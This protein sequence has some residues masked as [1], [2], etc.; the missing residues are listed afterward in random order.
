MSSGGVEYRQVNANVSLIFK[1]WTVQTEKTPC[2]CIVFKTKQKPV[3]K[4]LFLLLLARGCAGGALPAN[5]LNGSIAVLGNTSGSRNVCHPGW[6]VL[7][8]WEMGERSDFFP[9]SWPFWSGCWAGSENSLEALGSPPAEHRLPGAGLQPGSIL[10]RRWSAV[11]KFE[12]P[13]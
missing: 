5:Q 8:R 11:M 2:L 1:T 7:A 12:V 3:T 4:R 10:G 9:P 13:R 6:V